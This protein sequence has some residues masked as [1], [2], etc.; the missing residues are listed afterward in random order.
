MIQ[1]VNGESAPVIELLDACVQIGR[2]SGACTLLVL[3]LD[4]VKCILEM[5]FFVPNKV[6]LTPHLGGMLIGDRPNQ[7]YVQAGFDCDKKWSIQFQELTV[8]K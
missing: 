2:W 5:D 7:C 8:P 3:P 4:N 1:G 6:T